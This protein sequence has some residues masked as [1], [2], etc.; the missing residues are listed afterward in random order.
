MIRDYLAE[1]GCDV[2]GTSYLAEDDEDTMSDG[3]AAE[4]RHS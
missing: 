3:D 1:L 2:F 4:F